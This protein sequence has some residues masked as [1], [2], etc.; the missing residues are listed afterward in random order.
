MATDPILQE[1]IYE[2][3]KADIRC[4][5]FGPAHH[6]D[7]QRI[8]DRHRA[9]VT[10]VREALCRL[11]GEGLAEVARPRGF[12]V[13]ALDGPMLRDLYHYMAALLVHVIAISP[14]SALDAALTRTA[15]DADTTSSVNLAAVFAALFA[16]LAEASGNPEFYQAVSRSNDRLSAVRIAETIVIPDMRHELLALYRHPQTELRRRLSR[17]ISAYYRRRIKLSDSIAASSHILKFLL[18]PTGPE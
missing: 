3:L 9:S 15:A 16:N 2:A 10:P 6:F 14:E 7:L 8:S 1:R 13:A 17:Q 18:S 12:R 5:V 4:G 11:V